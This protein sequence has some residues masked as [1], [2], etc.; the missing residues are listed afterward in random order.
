M[1]WI[2]TLFIINIALL[3]IGCNKN[4][5]NTIDTAEL[6]NQDVQDEVSTDDKYN[7]IVE[8]LSSISAKV[9]DMEFV[10]SNITDSGLIEE[11]FL[12]TTDIK[13]LK[14]I[15]Y[16]SDTTNPVCYLWDNND[17]NKMYYSPDDQYAETWDIYDYETGELLQE[18]SVKDIMD[19]YNDEI[20]K[21]DEDFNNKLNDLY[22]K[23]TSPAN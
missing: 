15:L 10:S 21:L 2:K 8:A 4:N 17:T 12:I 16:Y 3:L 6:I 7:C 5:K 20:D 13:T 22:D 9:E 23:Y 11:E 1:N 19:I 14:C 18:A